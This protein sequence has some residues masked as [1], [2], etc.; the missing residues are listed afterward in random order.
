M[1]RWYE[2]MR[3]ARWQFWVLFAFLLVGG[4]LINLWERAGEAHVERRP[5]AE[6]PVQLGAWQQR[7]V[8]A[9]FD[10]ATEAVLLADDY[11]A[12]D[13]VRPDGTAANFYVGYYASQRNGATYHSPLNCL[14]GTGWVMN[15]P[16]RIL[17]Q[18]AGG[19]PAIEA[20]RYIIEHGSDRQVLIY[21]YQGRGRALASE[22]WGKIYTVLDSVRRRRSDGAMVRVTVPVRGSEAEAL[23]L[24]TDLAAQAAPALPAFV[25]N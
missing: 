21:W 17:V 20:N 6:F 22:Y 8:D 3:T 5:L 24:A 23:Q 13:Y 19:G 16:G 18:P 25:P 15:E 11:L 1:S 12:R 4:A 9:R 2:V 10:A 14:P 7:G